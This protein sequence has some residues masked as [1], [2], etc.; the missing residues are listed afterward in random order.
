M[1]FGTLA[2]WL[3]W[4]EGLHPQAIELG[5]ERVGRV[6]RRLRPH[7]L[8]TPVVTVG[9]TN[10][11]GSCAAFIEAIATAEGYAV[12]LYG[13]PHLLRYNERIHIRGREVSDAD[14]CIA[15]AGVDA[16]R[17]DTPLTYFEFGTLAAL[18]L[19][20]AADLDLVVLEVGL[21][22]RLDAVNIVDPDVAVVTSVGLDHCAWLGDGIDAIAREKAGIFRPG[23]PA[24]IGARD[25]PPALIDAA[26]ARGARILRAGHEFRA[27]CGPGGWTWRG[28]G[29]TRGGLPRP[30]LGGGHQLANAA[31]A[32]CALDALRGLLPVGPE[33]IRAGLTGVRLAGRLQ[34]LERDPLVLLD[35]AHNP[36]AMEALVQALETIP[37]AGGW[38]LVFGCMADKD[39][40]SMLAILAPRVEAWYPCDLEAPRAAA[41]SAITARIQGL[42]GVR[43][44]PWPDPLQALAAARNAGR[45]VLVTGS[46]HTVAAVLATHGERREPAAG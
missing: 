28:P 14:L 41:A 11:K 8:K 23:R 2:D 5:L 34:V 20:A 13:S 25:A 24:V 44:R 46:F 3:R 29:A 22:G 4:Q 16:A 18:S 32:L 37:G 39:L 31:S 35:V 42:T 7:G 12:G 30:A 15:F 33:A 40:D 9:G 38:H 26:A 10:G 1:R 36:P 19:F 27:A 6:W 43:P 45:R 17:G 21:G